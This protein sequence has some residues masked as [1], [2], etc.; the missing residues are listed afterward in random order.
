MTLEKAHLVLTDLPPLPLLAPKPRQ[1]LRLAEAGEFGRQ[2]NG[3]FELDGGIRFRPWTKVPIATPEASEA[4]MK[5]AG[6]LPHLFCL[7]IGDDNRSDK[8][9]RHMSISEHKHMS[10]LDSAPKRRIE[11]FTGAGRR[12]T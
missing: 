3:E 10:E 9:L 8:G 4:R 5:I 11:V 1:I 2:I 7:S 12:R 6:F